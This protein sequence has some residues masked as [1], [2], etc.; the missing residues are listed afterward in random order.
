MTVIPKLQYLRHQFG[1]QTRLLHSY[2]ILLLLVGVGYLYA[3]ELTD[4]LSSHWCRFSLLGVTCER[5]N[6][7]GGDE[8]QDI[9]QE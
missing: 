9:A 3:V 2:T 5:D 8:E 6:V 7:H 1:L 4:R